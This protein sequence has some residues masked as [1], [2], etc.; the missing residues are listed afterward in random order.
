MSVYKIE[1][2]DVNNIVKSTVGDSISAEDLDSL[3]RDIVNNDIP[4]TINRLDQ[5]LIYDVIEYTNSREVED[6]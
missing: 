2:E 4:K 1:Y 3:V 5:E 6:G